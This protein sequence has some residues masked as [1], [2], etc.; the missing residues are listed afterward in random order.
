M[1]HPEAASR[2]HPK[3]TTWQLPVHFPLV[4]SQMGRAGV[5]HSLEV[6]AVAIVVGV[7]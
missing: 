3:G 1:H 2:E 7:P 5:S 4:G 6:A